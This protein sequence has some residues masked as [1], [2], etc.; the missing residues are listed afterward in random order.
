MANRTEDPPRTKPQLPLA[1]TSPSSLAVSPA[2]APAAQVE[3]DEELTHESFRAI[4][5]SHQ[6]AGRWEVADEIEVRAFC[7]EVTL[8]FTQADLP[9]SGV[10]EIDALSIC[11]EVHIIVPDGA[12]VELDGTPILGGIEQHARKKKATEAI[13]EWVTGE[14]DN[15]RRA[16]TQSAEPPYFHI[17][18]RAILGN[19][20]VSGR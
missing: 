18:A 15:D 12:E 16:P 3:D 13:R 5:S 2:A 11:G 17:E 7:G 8:D 6:R 1:P 19:I 4:L 14:S 10:V 20:K 9:P